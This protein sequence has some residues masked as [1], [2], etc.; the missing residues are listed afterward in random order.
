VTELGRIVT[1]NYGKFDG[2]KNDWVTPEEIADP[3]KLPNI[4]GYNLLI[5]PVSIQKQIKVANTSSVLH[6]PDSFTEDVKMLTNVGQV[7]ALGPLCY[8]DPNLKPGEPGYP[9][10]R[11]LGPWCKVGDYVVWGKH[12]GQKIMIQG[13]SYVLLQDEL[14][15]FT[16]DDPSDINPILNALGR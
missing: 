16:L 1:G 6:L 4:K 13:V 5:R 7:K 11:Y 8:R 10:G 9:H 2:N 14:I 3:K 15:L 12:Q